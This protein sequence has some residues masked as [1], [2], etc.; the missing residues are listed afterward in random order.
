MALTRTLA[1]LTAEILHRGDLRSVR[2]DPNSTEL[3]RDINA[4]IM[5]LWRLLGKVCPD[6]YHSAT[7][8]S[9]TVISG[10][11]SYALASGCFKVTAV[12]VQDGSDWYQL[13]RY[14]FSERNM[15]QRA[16]EKRFTRHRIMGTNLILAPTPTWSG[17]CRVYYM[18]L[19]TLLS[20][21]SDTFDGIAGYEEYVILD[22]ILKHKAR[23]EEDAQ[24]IVGQLKEIE[25]EIRETATE[26]DDSEP[27]TWRDVEA[28]RLGSGW[29]MW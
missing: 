12:D 4:S 22:V 9:V 27:D 3:T 14:S 25:S 5:K 28:E 8:Q 29:P 16:G 6:R 17:T 7:P 11:A 2:A 10:T 21:S 20:G 13:A 15:Y 19:P 26:L 24:L 23:D 1:Q 18:P